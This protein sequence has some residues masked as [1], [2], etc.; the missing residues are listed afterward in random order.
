MWEIKEFKSQESMDKFIEKNY[1]KIQYTEI[2]INNGYCIEYRKLRKVYWWRK[3]KMEVVVKNSKSNSFWIT[4]Y[5]VKQFSLSSLGDYRT[6][7]EFKKCFPDSII[8]E[9]SSYDN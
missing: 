1:N 6:V 5:E 2:F 4:V 8:V 9:N 7:A 3:L